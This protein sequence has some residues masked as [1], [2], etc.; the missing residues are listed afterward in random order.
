MDVELGSH[1]MD[2]ANG[3][4]VTAT[5]TAGSAESGI[6]TEVVQSSGTIGAGNR[7]S[8]ILGVVLGFC[9]GVWGVL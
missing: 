2:A 1:S 9:V 8:V 3:G 6:P 4:V 7:R 5:V